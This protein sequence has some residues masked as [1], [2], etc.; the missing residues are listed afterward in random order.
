MRQIHEHSLACAAALLFALLAVPTATAQDAT[1]KLSGRVLGASGKST[2][3]VTLWNADGFL[4]TP[5]KQIRIAPDA[6]TQFEFQVPP[7]R[8]VLSAFEDRNAN[9]ILDMGVF[10][11]KEPS[12][13]WHSFNGWHKPR[14]DEVAFSLAADTQNADITLK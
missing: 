1:F 10:G 8:W 14:F 4:K 13:F 3:Y 5:I 2:V 11:P 9:G 6:D 7:G 12:G